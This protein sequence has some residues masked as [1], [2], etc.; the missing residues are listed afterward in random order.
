MKANNN[1]VNYIEGLL[2]SIHTFY[3]KITIVQNVKTKRIL[4]ILMVSKESFI[5][6]FVK[7]YF[8]KNT[9]LLIEQGDN[10]KCNVI[11]TSW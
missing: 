9:N 1:E 10:V 5:L 6:L 3:K 2:A 11:N 7:V 4:R 8:R